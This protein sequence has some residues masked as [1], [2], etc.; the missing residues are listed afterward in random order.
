M[1]TGS[2]F[3]IR[4]NGEAR[5]YRY[6]PGIDPKEGK[7]LDLRLDLRRHSLTGPERG[8]G[9]SGSA[10]L[11]LA[12]LAEY[13]ENDEEALRFYQG[14]KFAVVGRLPQDQSWVLTEEDIER[15]LAML[16]KEILESVRT[17]S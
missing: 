12:I 8:Y 17:C 13:L 4:E 10:Q 7:P 2:H 15:A 1:K 3:G 11:S 5:A 9:G 14:F 16:R 6:L